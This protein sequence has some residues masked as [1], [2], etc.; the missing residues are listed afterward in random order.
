MYVFTPS[1]SIHW[2]VDIRSVLLCS[3]DTC[4]YYVLCTISCQINPDEVFSATVIIPGM[5][6]SASMEEVSLHQQECRIR[7]RLG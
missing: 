3:D 5:L 6:V 1:S 4:N 2:E 7:V